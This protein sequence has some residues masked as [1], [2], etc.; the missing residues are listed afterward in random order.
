MP[1]RNTVSVDER[2]WRAESDARTIAE[3]ELIKSDKGR[4]SSAVKAGK[5]M[6]KRLSKEAQYLG[7][8]SKTT[9]K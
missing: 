6:S 4:F 7:G 9:K 8:I 2:R 1:K 5:E 3:A